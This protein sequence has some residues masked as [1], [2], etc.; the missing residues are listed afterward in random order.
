MMKR[1]FVVDFAITYRNRI[2]LTSKII[3]DYEYCQ[4]YTPRVHKKTPSSS[5]SRT[6]IEN[7]MQMESIPEEEATKIIVEGTHS[8]PSEPGIVFLLLF[9]SCR[10]SI[11]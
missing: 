2:K 4:E 3:D 8:Y 1:S 9:E 10:Y 6:T 7:E 5:S 11:I